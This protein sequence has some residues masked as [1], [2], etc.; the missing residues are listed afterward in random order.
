MGEA[1]HPGPVDTQLDTLEER[2]TPASTV[3]ASPHAL[4]RVVPMGEPLDSSLSE[5]HD[6]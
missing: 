3:P 1:G 6:G 2:A 5:G 4:R